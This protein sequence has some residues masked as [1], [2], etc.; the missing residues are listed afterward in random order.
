MGASEL[1]DPA[2][3]RATSP[4]TSTGVVPAAM[5]SEKNR[6]SLARSMVL[7]T[8]SANEATAADA[9]PATPL[10]DAKLSAAWTV[11]SVRRS[12]MIARAN[13]RRRPAGQANAALEQAIS[14]QLPPSSQVRG[15]RSLRQP[16]VRGRFATRLAFELAGNQG[17]P[18]P[19]RQPIQLFIQQ[20]EHIVPIFSA[21]C[22]SDV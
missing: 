5:I 6:D 10:P 2:A 3:S 12:G 1:G 17:D 21:C 9:A 7:S 8:R 16:E 11:E 4:R 20:R 18:K 19:L 15:E 13:G 22:C 14:Q